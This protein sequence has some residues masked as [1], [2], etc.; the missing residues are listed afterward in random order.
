MTEINKK[1]QFKNI[2]S[3]LAVFALAIFGFAFSANSVAA[4][5]VS[6]TFTSQIKDMGQA[7]ASWGNASWS[8]DTVIP[9]ETSMTVKIRS[10]DDAACSGE[11]AFSGIGDYIT[12]TTG[13][14]SSALSGL[15]SIIDD[16]RYV[17]YQV[18]FTSNSDATLTPTFA[19]FTINSSYYP[20]SQTLTSSAYNTQ[21]SVT[22]LSQLTWTEDLLTNTD[23]KFQVRTA[24]D[25]G[26]NTPGS[27]TAWCGPDNSS[28]GNC[29][30][31][32]Y[33]TNPL[34]TETIDDINRN[35][36][37]N[38][39]IQYKVWLTSSDGLDTPTL[40]L[41]NVEYNINAVPTAVSLSATQASDGTGYVQIEVVIDDADTETVKLKVEYS[42]DGGST[43]KDPVLTSYITTSPDQTTE[44]DVDNSQAYQIGM[45]TNKIITSAGANTVTI[46]WD[47]KSASN[48]TGAV[49]VSS[50]ETN[51][52]LRLTPH[53]GTSDGT[54]VVSAAV[55][56][57]DNTIPV[58]GTIQIN[59][60]DNYTTSKDTTLTLSATGASQM[61]FS[62]NNSSYS[63]YES[64][65]TSKSWDINDAT[66]GG[67][68]DEGAKTV[69]VIYK[70]AFGNVSTTLNDN[71]IYDITPPT[72]PTSAIDSQGAVSDTW[73]NDKN[74]PSFTSFTGEADI[75]GI[76]GFYVYFGTSATGADTSNWVETDVFDP[77]SFSTSDTRYLRILAKDNAGLYAD[78]DGV[79]TDC[80]NTNANRPTDPDCW[81]TIFTHK[82][83]I[84]APNTPNPVVSPVSWT[85]TNDFDFSWSDPG[86]TGGSG[87]KD[88]TYQTNAGTSETTASP[89]SISSLT[90]NAVGTKLFSVKA[91]DNAGNS[92]TNGTV[93]FYYDNTI[94][95]NAG[96]VT[97]GNGSLDD[98]W[99][100]VS[101]PS[102][103]WAVGTDSG[104]QSGVKEYDLYW[105]T[106]SI[107]TTV[108]TIVSS[109]TYNPTAIVAS[110]PYYLRIR[111]R[112]NA[113]NTSSW[114]TKFI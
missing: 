48:E 41:V 53:D 8:S 45:P 20:A 80:D 6:S 82:Y 112:D 101:D 92:G 114:E 108:T 83:D 34:G 74:D 7:N 13:A 31:A 57:V 60:N 104:D 77:A 96:T 85:N 70:D 29:S 64:Y 55:F 24:P 50:N 52:K 106:S 37:A 109:N 78:P 40:S 47:T 90:S 22:V 107:G 59:S 103:I 9:A 111:T 81:A 68:S 27:W 99:G 72:N 67:N 94:P 15:S 73:N 18:T 2:F 65:G 4:A 21:D 51:V 28:E 10:C 105:G 46:K 36:S 69:Y 26:S 32:T 12:M 25:S 66:Y 44:P 84:D 56:A 95:V 11:T 3:G 54:P 42:L 113:L 38:Q 62:N 23:I 86:D 79:S 93:N 30:S 1:R 61:K 76:D 14:G 91:N 88:Y 43:W 19:D 35:G 5:A 110:T 49:G 58:N 63:T 97:D 102:F 39:W 75:N 87:T 33:F 100:I 89:T 71:I 98:A 16:H 17:Q